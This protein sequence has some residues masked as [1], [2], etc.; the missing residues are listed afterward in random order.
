MQKNKQKRISYRYLALSSDSWVCL[1]EFEC[2]M[3]IIAKDTTGWPA[4]F[5]VKRR[6]AEYRRSRMKFNLNPHH[7]NETMMIRLYCPVFQIESMFSCSA[8]CV[9]GRKESC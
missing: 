7:E 9:A 4:T 2:F 1:R 8:D 5:A 3:S 6:E